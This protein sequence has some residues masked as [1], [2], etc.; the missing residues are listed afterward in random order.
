[1]DHL[2]NER[3]LAQLKFAFSPGAGD[4]HDENSYL[5][6]YPGDDYVDVMGLDHYYLNDAADLLEALRIVVSTAKKHGKIPALTEFGA[7]DGLSNQAIDAS[8]WFSRSFFDPLM[9]DPVASRIA[10][11]LAWRNADHSHFFV[12]YPKHP[13]ARDFG[14][15]CADPRFVLE[16]AL[17][18]L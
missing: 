2:R 4:V 10:Y 5:F 14:T 8:H 13:G 17:G 18:K 6:R 12:P 9:R 3:G 7:R 11:A 1:M 16:D 15:V